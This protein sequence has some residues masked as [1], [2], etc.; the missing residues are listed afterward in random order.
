MSISLLYPNIKGLERNRIDVG[1]CSPEKHHSKT[2]GRHAELQSLAL[3]H[4]GL[5]QKVV[6]CNQEPD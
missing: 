3:G 6:G 1:V 2:V 4:L 5:V